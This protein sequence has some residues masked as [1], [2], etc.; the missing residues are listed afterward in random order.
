VQVKAEGLPGFLERSPETP[1]DRMA[2]HSVDVRLTSEDLPLNRVRH[3][4]RKAHLDL[5]GT[6]A[7]GRSRLKHELPQHC[8]KPGMHPHLPERSLYPGKGIRTGA[9]PTR[10][11]RSASGRTRVARYSMPVARRMT[12]ASSLPPVPASSPQSAQ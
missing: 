7:E 6:N 10:P 1:F 2:R 11:A 8:G 12:P 3:K 9:P 4:D 5:T